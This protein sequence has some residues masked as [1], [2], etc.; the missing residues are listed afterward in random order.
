[1]LAATGNYV[2][3][4]LLWVATPVI[5]IWMGV[6]GLLLGRGVKPLVSRSQGRLGRCVLV[7]FLAGLA[8]GVAA[9][10][11]LLLL[12]TLGTIYDFK[13]FVLAIFVVPPVFIAISFTVIYAS[14][15]VPARALVR[16][17]GVAFA[18]PLLALVGGG[19]P[20]AWYAYDCRQADLARQH[21][22]ACLD[23]LYK[24]LTTNYRGVRPPASLAALITQN[25]LPP[26]RLRCRRPSNRDVDYFYVSTDLP[27]HYQPSMKIL[28]CDYIEN[29]FG[30]GRAV[31]FTNGD[32]RWYSRDELPA[33]LALPENHAFAAALSQAEKAGPDSVKARAAPPAS[34]P[35]GKAKP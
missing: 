24:V 6:G 34:T 21:S 18:I 29:Q 33:L 22:L 13:P 35:A 5:A 16:I 14:F 15:E 2:Q 28:A 31:V 25:I 32:V 27:V 9:F 20:A 11:A 7:S 10:V 26:D 4:W 17:S 30:K 3:P 8:G 23:Y 12:A 1:V 19:G